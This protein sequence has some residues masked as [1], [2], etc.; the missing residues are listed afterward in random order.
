MLTISSFGALQKFWEN[1]HQ[2]EPMSILKQNSFELLHWLLD[3]AVH[4]VLI[5]KSRLG[6]CCRVS[7]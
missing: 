3:L 6:L 5:G 7:K 4:S 1:L 2:N